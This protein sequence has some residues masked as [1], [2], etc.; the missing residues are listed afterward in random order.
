MRT[1]FE[2][3]TIESWG[4]IWNLDRKR[5]TD[6]QRVKDAAGNGTHVLRLHATAGKSILAGDVKPRVWEVRRFPVVRFAY[7]IPT[8]VPVGLWLDRFDT[9]EHGNGRVCIG[10][11]EARKCAGQKDLGAYSLTDDGQ[12]HSVEIDAR[13]VL[14]AFPDT[15]HLQAFSLYTHQNGEEGHEFWIDDFS[16]E[17]Q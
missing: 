7:R 4:H 2:D 11:T 13:T 1:D 3:D 9:E 12:W 15:T 16:I 5:N 10:G 8:G 6:Y 17:P 14:K